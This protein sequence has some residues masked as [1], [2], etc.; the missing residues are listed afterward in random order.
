MKPLKRQYQIFV[1]EMNKHGDYTKAYAK[2]YPK[3]KVTSARVK[4]YQLSQNVTISGL[5]KANS[6]KIDALAAKEATQRLQKEIVYDVLTAT[7][8][9]ELLR[10]ISEGKMMHKVLKPIWNDEIKKWESTV[11][12][13][14]EPSLMDRLKAIELHNRMTGDNA[15]EKSDITVSAPLNESQVKEMLNLIK[16]NK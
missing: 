11:I 15:P 14:S 3:A 2:A 16:K 9:K 13:I 8:K 6:D 4:G 10:L 12:A 7:R 1:R 5:I